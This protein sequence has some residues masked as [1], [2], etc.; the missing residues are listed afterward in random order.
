MSGFEEEKIKK[1]GNA[2][3]QKQPATT[4]G[5]RRV[6]K[7]KTGFSRLTKKKNTETGGV[8]MSTPTPKEK[9]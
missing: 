8:T 2:Y 9:R 4:A 6:G 3:A 1:K 5:R 7:W